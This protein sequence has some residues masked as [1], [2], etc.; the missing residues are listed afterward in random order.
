MKGHTASSLAVR[1]A[2]PAPMLDALA[3]GLRESSSKPFVG[4]KLP[5]LD[6][7]FDRCSPRLFAAR[8]W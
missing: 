7:F 4:P 6:A 2:P 1:G 5:N 8:P 3:A